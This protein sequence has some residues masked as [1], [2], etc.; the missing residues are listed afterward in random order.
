MTLSRSTERSP[1][2]CAANPAIVRPASSSSA[3]SR[4]S[5]TLDCTTPASALVSLTRRG[6][7]DSRWPRRGGRSRCASSGCAPASPI[8]SMTR[9]LIFSIVSLSLSCACVR[10]CRSIAASPQSRRPCRAA[11]ELS[12][13]DRV[14]DEL[15]LGLVLLGERHAAVERRLAMQ[16]LLRLLRDVR[17]LVGEQRLAGRAAHRLLGRAAHEDHAGR[18]DRHGVRVALAVELFGELAGVD[19]DVTEVDAEPLLVLL[20]GRCARARSPRPARFDD[21][22]QQSLGVVLLARA[23]R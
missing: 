1:T 5:W 10:A 21:D 7:R 9:S 17:Q 20:R 18:A 4:S 16:A 11:A 3:T 14:L 13:V 6:Y 12:C 2:D 22:L 15:G 8:S 19:A 23:R